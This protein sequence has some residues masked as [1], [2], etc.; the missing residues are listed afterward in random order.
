MSGKSRK[1]RAKRLAQSK[2]KKGRLVST[3]AVQPK[4]TAAEPVA[5]SRVATPAPTVPTPAPT[6]LTPAPKP[7]APGYS[8][9]TAELRRIGILAGIVLVILV[10]LALVLS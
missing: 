5:P 4:A 1:G 9:V 7:A 3:A 2:K 8:L 10:V 6:V